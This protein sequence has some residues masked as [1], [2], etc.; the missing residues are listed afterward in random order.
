MMGLKSQDSPRRHWTSSKVAASLVLGSWWA[1][2]VHLLLCTCLVV[3]LLVSVDGHQFSTKDTARDDDADAS[4]GA[5]FLSQSD[6]TTLV[7][8]ALAIVR[9]VA[10]T[11]ISTL[12]FGLAFALLSNH[13]AS[14]KEVKR[15][16]DHRIAPFRLMGQGAA[17]PLLL[18]SLSWFVCLAILPSQFFAPMLTGAINW[19]P[20]TKSSSTTQT[21]SLRTPGPGDRWSYINQFQ[22]SR[23]YV[24]L[25]ALGMSSLASSNNFDAG[26]RGPYRRFAPDLMG[27]SI[28]STIGDVDVPFW[29]VQSLDWIYSEADISDDLPMLTDI[30]TNSSNPVLSFSDR[31]SVPVADKN[32]FAANSDTGRVTIVNDH[33][34]TAS[35]EF[36][37]PHL[38]Q[39]TRWVIV[40]T[41]AL[42]TSCDAESIFGPVGD[43]YLYKIYRDGDNAVSCFAFARMS[44]TA[45]SLRCKDC[46]VALDGV[47]ELAVHN[48]STNEALPNSLTDL[49][50]SMMPEVLFYMEVANNSLAP[51]W[52]NL[53]GYTRGMLS[54]AYQSSFN[55]MSKYV[56]TNATQDI[57]TYRT[58]L[59][60]LTAS[61]TRW[62]V[63][64]W[65]ASNFL[66]TVA[67]LGFA[68]V[69][70]KGAVE[71]GS[72]PALAALLVDASPVIAA[73]GLKE[74]AAAKEN[75][76]VRLTVR[77]GHNTLEAADQ[78]GGQESPLLMSM[79]H[80]KPSHPAG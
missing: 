50:V 61:I 78:R 57:A 66:L 77:D 70:A 32:P 47:V 5:P 65:L 37:K 52:Q 72:S 63:Y 39:Q 80:A 17:R 11:W 76:Q 27:L 22:N 64:T 14:L 69:Q 18:L 46:R 35:D 79:S 8:V 23:Y 75:L 56:A 16:L 62:R 33:E 28:N 12:G 40:A 54:I 20:D 9:A 53:D 74:D 3:V 67:G 38:Q 31:S 58:P 44:Y 59:P 68:V 29:E 1:V 41:N 21:R 30:I 43:L 34:F 7:S 36:P 13:G 26:S 24:V 60:V 2:V 45:G 55:A 51:T 73:G 49:A 10:A 25:N 42:Q 19:I 15:L 6:V 71:V 4:T 48:N